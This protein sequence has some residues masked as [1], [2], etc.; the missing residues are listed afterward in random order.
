LKKARTAFF[1]L[2]IREA[3]QY[4]EEIRESLDAMENDFPAT[5]RQIARKIMHG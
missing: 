4:A 5:V 2:Y 3:L 1:N